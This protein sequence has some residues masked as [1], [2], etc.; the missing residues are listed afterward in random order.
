MLSDQDDQLKTYR[1]LE[2]YRY[3]PCEYT[4]Q[5]KLTGKLDASWNRPIDQSLVNEI[6]L[7]KVD[8]YSLL[9][10]NSLEL[11][12]SIDPRSKVL[13]KSLTEE[14]L[15]QLLSTEGIGLPVASTILRF[16]NPNV[17]Q[18]IDQRAYRFIY[19]KELN[20]PTYKSEKAKS[21]QIELYIAYLEKLKEVAE[22]LG[23]EFS[24]LDR[25]LYLEDQ[26]LNK[27]HTIK[28]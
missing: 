17:Y 8:R 19:G 7:W 15:T 28:R 25:A 2:N 9:G 10:E 13:S 23:C 12:N 26:K 6:L 5:E 1:S 24:I 3:D 20:L 27:S 22:Y 21:G 11:L 18:I 4:Y 14:V 16:R